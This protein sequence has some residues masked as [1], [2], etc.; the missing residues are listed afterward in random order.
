M[1][2]FAVTVINEDVDCPN[3]RVCL[4]N[5]ENV[6]KRNKTKRKDL[7]EEERNEIAN[8]LV[9]N[10]Y[11][12]KMRHGTIKKAASKF[13]LHRNTIGLIWNR[14]QQKIR[15]G[16]TDFDL[17]PRKKSTNGPKSRNWSIVLEEI[18]SINCSTCKKTRTKVMVL[19]MT[20]CFVIQR[21]TRKHLHSWRQLNMV[22]FRR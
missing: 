6:P 17:S 8:Y 19:S 2:D 4:Q 15:E 5:L 21:H 12:G 9:L 13:G 14:I 3:I 22:E 10:C 11:N 16:R 20:M 7:T 1:S 18:T